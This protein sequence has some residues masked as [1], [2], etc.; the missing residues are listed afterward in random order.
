M[1]IKLTNE[2]IALL[3]KQNAPKPKTKKP[4]LQ[5]VIRMGVTRNKKPYLT[6][7]KCAYYK[8]Q[9]KGIIALLT[10]SRFGGVEELKAYLELM[11]KAEFYGVEG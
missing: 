4:V 8:H 7:G 6:F 11:L 5:D 3:R 10:D 9:V 2:Q 1:A